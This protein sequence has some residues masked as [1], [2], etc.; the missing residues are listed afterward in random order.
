MVLLHGDPSPG[1]LSFTLLH[2]GLNMY[3][4]YLVGPL[5]ER[6]YGPTRLVAFYVI[7]AIGASLATFAFGPVNLG[8]GASGAIF[9]LFGVVFAA[10]RLHLPILDAASRRLASQVGML[11]LLNILL[12]F[13]LGFVDN[14]AH[15]G[16]VITGV[17]VAAAVAPGNV[18]TLRSRWQPGEDGTIAPGNILLTPIGRIGI[19]AVLLV[20]MGICAYLGWEHW[21]LVPVG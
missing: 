2:L 8:T 16:G 10:M 18:P 4:L 19:V 17:L 11:I 15:I 13:S 3:A 9:G 21:R 7:A 14:F 1:Q 20:A 12:G 5:V 6:L